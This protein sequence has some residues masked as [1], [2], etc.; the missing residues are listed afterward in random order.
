MKDFPSWLEE[1]KKYTH[2]VCLDIPSRL[3]RA[4]KILGIQEPD[5]NTIQELE[6]RTDFKS[7]NRNIKSQLRR[8]V[9]LYLEYKSQ[10]K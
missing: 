4:C 2:R 6:L 10:N 5:E 9:R 3:R 7:M 8:S 1:E